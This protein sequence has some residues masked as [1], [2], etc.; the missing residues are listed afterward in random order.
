MMTEKSYLYDRIFLSNRNFTTNNVK[1][2]KHSRF[3][4]PL[5]IT[6]FMMRAKKGLQLFLKNL[7]GEGHR[8]FSKDLLKK[9]L[10]NQVLLF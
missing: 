7:I 2:V 8:F 4:L 1:I 5:D 3:F 10:E 6:N 9:S